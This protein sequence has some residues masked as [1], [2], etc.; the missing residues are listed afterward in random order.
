MKPEQIHILLEKYWNCETTVSE[1]KDLQDFFSSND[2]PMELQEYIPVFAYREGMQLLTLDSDF[3]KRINGAI[4]QIESKKQYI[5]VK[6]FTPILKIAAS[7]LLIGGLAISL[8]F[9]S[10]QNNK[11]N[12]AET[13]NDPNAAIKHATFALE[14]LSDALQTGENATRQTLQD[15]DNMNIDWAMLDSITVAVS[16]PTTNEPSEV[17]QE[18]ENL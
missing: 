10:K 13:Y 18:T 9:I 15:I 17:V 7:L 1:E 14:K 2:V 8:F 12:F 16:A 3:D 4:H 11:P 6:I 5:T